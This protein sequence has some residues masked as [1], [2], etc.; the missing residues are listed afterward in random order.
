MRGIGSGSDG[1]CSTILEPA[2]AS[3]LMHGSWVAMLPIREHRERIGYQGSSMI[4][5][6]TCR[7]PVEWP[8]E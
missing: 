2:S 5:L 4:A 7:M 8:F 3:T 6:L 1:V